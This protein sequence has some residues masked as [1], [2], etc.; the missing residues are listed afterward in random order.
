MATV[1]VVN[2][3]DVTSATLDEELLKL[4]EVENVVTKLEFALKLVVG[5]ENVDDS[6]ELVVILVPVGILEV[7]KYDGVLPVEVTDMIDEF[8][9]AETFMLGVATAVLVKSEVVFVEK[10]KTELEVDEVFAAGEIVAVELVRRVPFI[11]KLEVTGAIELELTVDV[12]FGVT[13][14]T[15]RAP[16]TLPWLTAG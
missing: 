1:L 3:D 14:D 16:Q 10:N 9:T 8:V 5:D 12:A 2:D 4:D 6:V 11:M 15:N 7:L 13:F